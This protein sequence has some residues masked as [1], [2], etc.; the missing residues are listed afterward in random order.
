MDPAFWLD[1]VLSG[2]AA[3]C[4]VVLT[5]GAWLSVVDALAPLREWLLRRLRASQQVGEREE[6]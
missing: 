4:V 5:Y 3:L 6:V 2:C 1:P